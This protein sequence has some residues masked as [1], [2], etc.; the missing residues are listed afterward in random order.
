MSLKLPDWI[1]A[2]ARRTLLFLLISGVALAL[3][4]LPA[5]AAGCGTVSC[6]GERGYSAAATE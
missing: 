2:D 1:D 5:A 3:S 6:G 4:F